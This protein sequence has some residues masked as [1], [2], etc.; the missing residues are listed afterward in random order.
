MPYA[1]LEEAWGS[2]FFVEMPPV[3][4]ANNMDAAAVY[5][6][7][8]R[9]TTAQPNKYSAPYD[10]NSVGRCVETM[11]NTTTGSYVSKK[12]RKRIPNMSRTYERLNEHSG[13][14][15][16]GNTEPRLIMGEDNQYQLANPQNLPNYFNTDAPITPYTRDLKERME[17]HLKTNGTGSN[18]LNDFLVKENNRL[19]GMVED[20][21]KNMGNERDTV[22]DLLIFLLS[23][24]FVIIIVD[25]YTK[26]IK[27]Y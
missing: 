5:E 3:I 1:T 16:R 6:S 17:E 24:I 11:S 19:K 14:P 15:N 12:R 7:H 8:A 27:R 22:F 18:S 21:K 26:L 20:M 2:N 13:V 9:R 23:G 25:S 10:P 4:N